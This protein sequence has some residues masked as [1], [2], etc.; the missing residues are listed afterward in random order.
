ME[1][2]VDLTADDIGEMITILRVQVFKLHVAPFAKNLGIQERV[3]IESEEGKGPHGIKIL[4][5][6]NSMYPNVEMTL[7]VKIKRGV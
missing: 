3:L 5:K 6:I 4:Q 1:Y 7:N 2:D